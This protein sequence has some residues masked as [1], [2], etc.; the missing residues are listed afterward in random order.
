MEWQKD[1][2]Q[3]KAD[4]DRDGYI[5]LRA[6][7]ATE[8]VEDIQANIKRYIVDVVPGLRETAAKYELQ[9]N[10]ETLMR[11][12]DMAVDDY[13][14]RLNHSGHFVKL[15]EMLLNDGVEQGSLQFFN[16][17]PRHGGITP[18][19]QDGFYFMRQ[20]NNALTMWLALDKVDDENGCIRYLPGSQIEGY[21]PHRRQNRTGFSQ[22]IT[23]FGEEDLKREHAI[24]ASPGDVLIHHA[25]IVHRA[26]PNPS[27][28]SRR[29]M[30]LIYYG[31][32]A[33]EDREWGKAEQE[34]LQEQWEK[35]GK[36]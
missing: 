28:R 24:D 17:P 33:K 20:P 31:K 7:V 16:K 5:V 25:M 9:G 30:G 12:S 29:A 21:R 2:K 6:F 4:F 13:F 34:R 14:K 27:D 18:P 22:G 3:I 1:S 10:K 32:N 19:H 8:Q 35:E 15:A 26:D 11:L 36:I 23:D